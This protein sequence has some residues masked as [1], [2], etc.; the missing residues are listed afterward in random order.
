MPTN[1]T[2]VNTTT[3]AQGDHAFDIATGDTVLVLPDIELKAEGHDA[4]GINSTGTDNHLIIRGTV[5]SVLG[6]GI[7]LGGGSSIRV[8]ENGLVSGGRYGVSISGSGGTLWNSGEIRTEADARTAVI[9]NMTSTRDQFTFFNN[10]TVEGNLTVIT[11]TGT[12]IN[13][14]LIIGRVAFLDD[15]LDPFGKNDTYDGREGQIQGSIFLGTGDDRA[16]GGAGSETFDAGA[17]DDLVD[18]GDGI[19]TLLFTGTNL[20]ALTIDLRLTDWQNTGELGR[21]KYL[22]IE[23]ITFNGQDSPAN[24]T[25]NSLNNIIAGG[26]GRDTL[27]GWLGNDELN[28]RGGADTLSGGDGNDTLIGGHG[29]DVLDGGTGQD[30]AV[31]SENEADYDIIRNTDGTITVA[32]RNNGQDGTDTLTNIRFARFE[33]ENKTVALI[34]SAPISLALSG[35]AVAENAADA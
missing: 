9:V 19:D 2:P 22:N 13:T 30:T 33:A 25:G 35:A 26:N 15:N 4:N 24:L 21:D 10:G 18:G 17:G 5:S 31:F 29:N 12:I 14:G 32:H 16:Y 27:E 1:Y 34:N 3:T 11:G 8:Q 6:D 23:N 28:G 7:V 20:S